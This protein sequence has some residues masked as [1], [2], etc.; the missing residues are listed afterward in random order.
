LHD[1]GHDDC[2][3]ILQRCREA[4]PARNLGGKV[5]IIDM[6]TGSAHGDRK[7]SEME[8]IQDVYMMYT[9]G[10]ERDETQWKRIFSDAGFSDNCKFMPVLGPYSVIEI[11]P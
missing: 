4:I 5:I 2:V 7:I 6:V 11:Y 8:A 10:M 1:R 3:K 9:A